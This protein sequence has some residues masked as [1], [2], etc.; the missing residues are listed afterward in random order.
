MRSPIA[1]LAICL[2]VVVVRGFGAAQA[3]SRPMHAEPRDAYVASVADLTAAV[4]PMIR[5]GGAQF[6]AFVVVPTVV[7][8]PFGLA[9]RELGLVPQWRLSVRVGALWLIPALAFLVRNL[10]TGVYDLGEVRLLVRN[11]FSNG[12]SEEFLFRGVLLSRLLSVVSETWAILRK[13]R[14]SASGI[15]ARICAA[16]MVISP[17]RYAMG[18]VAVRTR[19]LLVPAVFH[20]M[21]DAFTSSFAS[22]ATAML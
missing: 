7:L 12:F 6:V 14:S 11:T 13:L 20:T 1:Q 19:S 2:G 21:F 10:A 4:Y 22:S 5:Y 8:L 18:F 3:Q 16:R 15:M 9:R 17:S